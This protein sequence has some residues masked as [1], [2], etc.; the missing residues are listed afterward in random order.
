MLAALAMPLGSAATD[1]ITAIGS[2]FAAV[3][4]V[5]AVCVALWQTVGQE[6]FGLHLTSESVA[7]IGPEGDHT[8]LLRLTGVN[9]GR[10]PIKINQ[11]LFGLVVAPQVIIYLGRAAGT[12][13]PATLAPGDAVA[14]AWDKE[15]CE[16]EQEQQGGALTHFEFIDSL[17][18]KYAAPIPGMKATR[19]NWRLQKRYVPR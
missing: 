16:R 7:T 11:A 1:W 14:A 5:G 17:G 19:R 9:L 6:R 13:L 12:D 15:V 2:V 10:R 18:N 3:G 8:V 4:T